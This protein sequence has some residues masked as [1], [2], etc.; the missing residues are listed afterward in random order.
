MA[1]KKPQTRKAATPATSPA[2]A[3]KTDSASP[4]NKN[5]PPPAS[6]GNNGALNG[7]GVDS[8]T[9]ETANQSLGNGEPPKTDKTEISPAGG[10][11]GANEKDEPVVIVAGFKADSFTGFKVVSA[12]E[13]FRRAGRAWTKAET[14]VKANELSTDQITALLAEPML[15][16]VGITE[17]PA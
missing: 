15:Q 4:E 11:S 13:G 9:S 6:P 10:T 12:V 3:P 14:V 8:S 5:N 17:D 1:S 16:V 2:A 7:S